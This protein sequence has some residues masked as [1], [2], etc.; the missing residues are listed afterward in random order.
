MT[1]WKAHLQ[2]AI[3]QLGSQP[4]LADAMGCSQSKISWLLLTAKEISAEDALGVHRATGGKV[5]ASQL[6]P[7]LWNSP[8]HIPRF[9]ERVG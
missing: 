7:D 3:D 6:R 4:K 5:S 9:K 1:A 8:Q 2:T